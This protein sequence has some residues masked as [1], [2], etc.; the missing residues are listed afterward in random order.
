MIGK[1]GFLWLLASMVFLNAGLAQDS[2]QG[3]GQE[4]DRVPVSEYRVGPGDVLSIQV[5]G[6]S[7]FDQ[8]IR[9]S[10][11]G[12]IHIPYA[13][14]LP[15]AGMTVSM[16]ESEI[17]RE[18]KERKLVNEPW[19]Q[20][21]VAEHYAQPVFMVGEVTSP[22]Q[23][24]VTGEMRLLDAITRAGGLRAT[25]ADAAFLIR[26][27]NIT[28]GESGTPPADSEI[29]GAMPPPNPQEAPADAG[30]TTPN[31]R[32]MINL[33]DLT[34]GKRP[35][36]NIR[37]QGGDIFYVPRMPTRLIY[38]I[39]EVR[40]PG[41]YMLP[42]SYEH[43]TAAS[44]LAYAG[45]TIRETAKT[46][47]AFI[48]RRDKDGTEQTIEFNLMEIVKGEQPDIPMKPDDVLFVPRSITKMLGYKLFDMVGHMTHQMVIF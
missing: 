13:G 15:V 6:L 28:G 8:K 12:K 36:L 16:I 4:K 32:V 43:I 2:S 31:E 14:I 22:G 7:Q 11:S 41:A 48:V 26:R 5:F 10:N 35:E 24:V 47:K 37:L 23:F 38:I 40:N 29:P 33:A 9:I 21:H 45:G 3:P 1:Y 25:A 18:L 44:A 39:G 19:V 42:H 30:S 27:R 34:D 20:V 46:N 17:A